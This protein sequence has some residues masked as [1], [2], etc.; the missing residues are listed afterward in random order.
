M[1]A[2]S[3]AATWALLRP[4]SSVRWSRVRR[5]VFCVSTAARY[6]ASVMPTIMAALTSIVCQSLKKA[7]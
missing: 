5:N 7:R 6:L 1:T 4:K 2:A 3:V